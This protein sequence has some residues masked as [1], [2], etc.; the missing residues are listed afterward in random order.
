MLSIVSVGGNISLLSHQH[1]SHSLTGHSA[2]TPSEDLMQLDELVMLHGS[3]EIGIGGVWPGVFGVSRSVRL[4][5]ARVS[6]KGNMG[7]GGDEDDGGKGVME[8]TGEA[9]MGEAWEP[10]PF[11][12]GTWLAQQML[13]LGY[14]PR[15]RKGTW[16]G[17]DG[18]V[19]D[20][21][22][23]TI[24]GDVGVELGGDVQDGG[25]VTIS[26]DVEVELGGSSLVRGN[27]HLEGSAVVKVCFIV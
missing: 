21:G 18:Y 7:H 5:M 12:L 14:M 2:E 25:G 1:K 22:G 26:G 8:V 17:G 6:S 4:R 3:L 23:V 20:G 15:S 9:V 24:S 27:V 19:Q 11:F 10:K 16:G 13:P